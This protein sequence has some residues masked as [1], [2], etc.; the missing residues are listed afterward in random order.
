MQRSAPSWALTKQGN[1]RPAAGAERW[2]RG[3]RVDR[4][5][6]RLHLALIATADL[7]SSA[8]RSMTGPATGSRCSAAGEVSGWARG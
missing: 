6:R 1:P 3:V 5:V 7:R 2:P 4:E 8:A